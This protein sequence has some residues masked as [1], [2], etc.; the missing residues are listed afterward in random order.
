MRSFLWYPGYKCDALKRVVYPHY[1]RDPQR[2]A[3]LS[4]EIYSTCI[5]ET[6][7]NVRLLWKHFFVAVFQDIQHVWF[8][9]DSA[10][11]HT[12]NVPKTHPWSTRQACNYRNGDIPRPPL[13]P[14]LSPG[15]FFLWVHLKLKVYHGKPRR[16]S[17]LK[18]AIQSEIAPIPS[19]L[20]KNAINLKN[21]IYQEKNS[22]FNFRLHY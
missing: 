9:Q 15:D 21:A 18:E 5:G 1:I 19:A 11:A 17:E 3:V 16:I 10:T 14:D 6:C 22:V 12:A 7:N 20:C 4:L 13:S 2:R 8:Q